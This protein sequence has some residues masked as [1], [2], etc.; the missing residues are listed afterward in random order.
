MRSAEALDMSAPPRHLHIFAPSAEDKPPHVYLLCEQISSPALSSPALVP[1]RQK[2]D[3]RSSDPAGE[4]PA[5]EVRRVL[6]ACASPCSMADR[7]CVTS[8]IASRYLGK[9]YV[10]PQ[11]NRGNVQQLPRTHEFLYRPVE[12]VDRPTTT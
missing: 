3:Q 6:A 7:M 11:C 1:T 8:L 12:R 9:P 2:H 4:V 5:L 10:F